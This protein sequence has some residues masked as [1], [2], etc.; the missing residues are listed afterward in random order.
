LS[1]TQEIEIYFVATIVGE[2]RLG[3]GRHSDPGAVARR[4]VLALT[5][6]IALKWEA[7][8]VS[9]AQD[10]MNAQ[11]G[12]A[13]NSRGKVYRKLSAHVDL[14]VGE[15]SQEALRELRR[16][17]A[18]VARL[19]FLRKVLFANPVLIAIEYLERN[20][21]EIKKVEIEAF[22]SFAEQAMSYEKWWGPLMKAWNDLAAKAESPEA[23]AEGMNVLLDAILRLDSKLAVRHGL[24][25]SSP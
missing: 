13:D 25:L 22:R 10:D 5:S 12:N 24:P 20:P 1:R 21:Q 23:V 9:A 18:R 3:R 17:Q 15:E 2:Y 19:E 14:R 4:D 16:D 11:L 8:Q 6:S 7:D